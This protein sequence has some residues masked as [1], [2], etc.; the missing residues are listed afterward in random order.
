M[1]EKKEEMNEKVLCYVMIQFKMFIS[2]YV[3]SFTV[4]IFDR[5]P[6]RPIWSTQS[7]YD[8]MS[9]NERFCID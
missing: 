1:N 5:L 7:E 9:L 4:F 2:K 3:Q 6:T 8:A